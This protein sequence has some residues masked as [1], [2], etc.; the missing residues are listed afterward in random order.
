MLNNLIKNGKF[1]IFTQKQTA[2]FQNISDF[3]ELSL[4]R[5]SGRFRRFT[6]DI[7]PHRFM[8]QCL[9]NTKCVLNSTSGVL[10]HLLF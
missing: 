2:I 10:E 9:S 7:D 8:L 5:T 1:A 3:L 6:L 4:E